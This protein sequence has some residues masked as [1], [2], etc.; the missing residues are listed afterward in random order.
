MFSFFKRFWDKGYF[1]KAFVITA[2]L[3]GFLALTH[4]LGWLEP[5]VK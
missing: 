5:F 3:V 1:G 2:A 4:F